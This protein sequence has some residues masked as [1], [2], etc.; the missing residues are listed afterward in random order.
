V[1]KEAEI[2]ER[3]PGKMGKKK[4]VA[5]RENHER[6]HKKS[7]W[8]RKEAW[9]GVFLCRECSVCESNFSRG[10]SGFAKGRKNGK[11]GKMEGWGGGGLKVAQWEGG[12]NVF[13]KEINPSKREKGKK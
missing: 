9:P 8:Q 10:G 2:N 3:V 12:K 11:R 7:Y 5:A 13:K 4:G 6:N 1:G